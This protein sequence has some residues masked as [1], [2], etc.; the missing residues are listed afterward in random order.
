MSIS[1]LLAN[2]SNNVC[3]KASVSVISTYDIF[4]IKNDN[5]ILF[6]FLNIHYD[7]SY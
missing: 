7:K 1:Y 4:A 3:K 5:A 2:C 6:M